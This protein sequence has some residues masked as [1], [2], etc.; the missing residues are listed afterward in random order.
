MQEFLFLNF[1]KVECSITKNPNSSKEYTVKSRGP[2]LLPRSYLWQQFFHD[3]S[4]TACT[5]MCGWVRHRGK[6]RGQDCSSLPSLTGGKIFDK[7][8]SIQILPVAFVHSVS[9]SEIILNQYTHSHL[10]S[11]KWLLSAPLYKYV[12]SKNSNCGY[13]GCFKF[14][15]IAILPAFTIRVHKPW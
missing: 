2:S 14:Q 10:F 5:C 1:E 4:K 6:E 9:R 12:T 3:L 13:V 7:Y 8:N 15:A 11:C